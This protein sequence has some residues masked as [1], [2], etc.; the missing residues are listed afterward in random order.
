MFDLDSA[1]HQ[2]SALVLS[3][4]S[5]RSRNIDELKD[6][7]YCEVERYIDAGFDQREAFNK[8][9]LAIGDSDILAS[10]NQKNKR[11]LEKL[12]AFEFGTI[13]QYQPNK[14]N[15]MISR[16]K[17][18]WQQSVLWAMAIIACAITLRG[19]PQ[20]NTVLMFVLLPLA[21]ANIIILGPK[22]SPKSSPSS[23]QCVFG[24]IKN[25]FSSR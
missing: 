1:V 5:I 9:I 16:K 17:V 22:S 11:F 19:M 23:I 21:M 13:G 2:W 12:C 15:N 18:Q 24:K 25:M 14:G 7:L 4:D 20:A 6:H 10:E 8:A 3:A